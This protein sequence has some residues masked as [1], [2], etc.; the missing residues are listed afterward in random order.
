[1]KL[2]GGRWRRWAR[3]LGLG[4]DRWRGWARWPALGRGQRP[5]GRRQRGKARWRQPGHGRWSD[6]RLNSRCRGRTG[7]RPE[8]RL[9]GGSPS[10]G[11]PRRRRE[12]SLRQGQRDKEPGRR[13]RFWIPVC[14]GPAIRGGPGDLQL[15]VGGPGESSEATGDLAGSERDDDGGDGGAVSSD[16]R[17][18][19]AGGIVDRSDRTG[20]SVA[21]RP[22]PVQVM[23]SHGGRGGAGD[24]YGRWQRRQCGSGGVPGRGQPPSGACRDRACGAVF[25]ADGRA[26]AVVDHRSV[27]LRQ[28][29]GTVPWSTLPPVSCRGP[30]RK[31]TARPCRM[32]SSSAESS[33]QGPE[34]VSSGSSG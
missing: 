21:C 25:G 12:Q 15:V 9:V 27:R 24:A 8:W 23:G 10:R 7:H 5:E 18:R 13:A 3:W 11:V 31:T 32:R 2:G 14:W 34:A 22:E 4:G 6:R 33:S 16:A 1:M 26:G 20:G 19:V 28:L 30:G 29:A 17:G